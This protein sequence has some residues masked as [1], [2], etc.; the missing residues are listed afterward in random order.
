M[1]DQLRLWTFRTSPF[2]GKVRAGFAEKGVEVELMEIHP[3]KRPPR[4]KELNPL[5]RVPV[6][7]VDGIAIRESSIILE[8]LEDTHPEP[9]LW[10]ADP[11]RRAEARMWA[12]LIDDAMLANLFLGLRKLAFGKDDVDPEDIVEQLHARVPKQ[13][14]RLEAGLA[15]ND[16]P[17]LM[18]EQFTYADL[19]GMP[20]AVRMPEWTPHLMPESH[21]FP[22][23]TAWLAALRDRPSAAAIDAKGAELVEA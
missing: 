6:L 21:E 9:A 5:N 17:W 22:L 19:A 3:A 8:W 15:V 14:P 13:W 20:L 16:G 7:E 10:P 23:C 11:D 2:A 12:R 1:S 18:G 4:L